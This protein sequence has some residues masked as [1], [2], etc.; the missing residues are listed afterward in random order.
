MKPN[1]EEEQ[2]IGQLLRDRLKFKDTYDKILSLS[3]VAIYCSCRP[4][5]GA[6]QILFTIN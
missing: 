4:V 5:C 1:P 2:I 6:Q 3:A